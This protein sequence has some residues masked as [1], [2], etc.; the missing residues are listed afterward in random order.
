MANSVKVSIIIPAYNAAETFAETLETVL[1]QTYPDW[2]AIIVNDG[3]SDDTAAIAAS[4]A[5]RDPRIRLISQSQGGEGAARNTGIRLARFDW[6]FF[7]DADDWI[8]PACLERITNALMNNPG[9]DAVHCGWARIAPDGTLVGEHR[10][11]QTG[12]LFLAFANLCAFPVHAC[13]IRRAFVEAVGYF[14][15]SLRTCA[16][17]DLWQRVARMGARFGSVSDV[18]VRYRMRPNSA[19]VDGF[20]FLADGLGRV[21]QGH[22]PDP[23]V[24][25]PN[26]SHANGLPAEQLPGAKLYF[27]CWPAGMV[28][29]RGGDARP[30]LNALSGDH[31][32]A[33][34]PERVAHNIF[35]ATLLPICQPPTIWEKLWPDLEQRVN[36]FLFAL[37]KQ[38][39]ATGLVRRVRI[40]LERLIL[41]HSTTPWP[42]TIGTTHAIKV[43]V[44]EPIRDVYPSVSME[45]LQCTVEIEGEHLGT[46]ELPVCDGLVS[47]YVLADAIASEFAWLIV[48]R[49]F[50]HTVYQELSLK[51]GSNGL[52]LQRGNLCLADGLTGMEYP[53]QAERPPPGKHEVWQEIHKQVGWTVFLQ[54]IWG[55]P[56]WPSSYF[57]DPGI[58]EQVATQCCA[59]NGWFI[60]EV[61]KD[62]PDVEVS[63]QEL[64][65]VLMVGGVALGVV[66]IPAKQGFVRAHELR[67]ALT[68][69]G[70]YELCRVAVR[71]GLLGKPLTESTP[72]RGRLAAAAQRFRGDPVPEAS[73]NFI[74]APGSAQ[75]LSRA[76]LPD[77][78][79]MVIGQRAH[80]VIGTSISRRAGF[81]AAATPE[82]VEAALVSGE[83]VIQMPSTCEYP[84]R[85]VYAP[86]LVWRP[87]L[88]P[89]A[90]ATYE[91]ILSLLPFTRSLFRRIFNNKAVTRVLGYERSSTVMTDRLPILMY[92][93][94]APTGTPV[95]ARYRVT[96]EAFEEQLRYLRDHGFYSVRLEDWRK[97][98]I[99]QKPLPGRAILLTFDDGYL[100]FLTYAWSLLS[101]YGFSAI[102]FLVAEEIGGSNRWDRV[103]GEEVP[104]LGWKEIRRLCDEGIEFGSHSTSHLRLTALPSHEIVREGARSRA[105][106]ERGLGLP[107]MSFAYPHGAEDRVVQHLIGAC[108]YVFGLSCRSGL[109][110]LHDPL[111]ALPRIEVTGSDSLQ[112]FIT[113]LGIHPIESKR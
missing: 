27:V 6:L 61:S 100:D 17:W 24:P 90:L 91:R 83:P 102:V 51:R 84:K 94:I 77:E 40:V 67:I 69:V 53:L 38:S 108:G 88:H 36:E 92:H 111:L 46:L 18:L 107:V 65:V 101:R 93:R 81:P 64:N 9:L 48:G 78:R 7:L 79:G 30:L 1:A 45:R 62:L 71:E 75:A 10:C 11:P 13:M 42:R 22:S 80:G 37:E 104:L 98:M 113:K 110:N 26:P 41:E 16:D 28:L 52:S 19:W 2:E 99:A 50:A 44:T 49:F 21:I 43:E 63:G 74:P 32:P 54:E 68:N 3:S 86:D 105:I 33:L 96:P 15:T 56:D 97:A 89:R 106:L 109:S 59:D 34:N 8:L 55:H 35:Y 70:G 57:Y 23:R 72:L 25:N 87:V 82:L 73:G 31:E 14:D 5:K 76:L 12:D 85:V 95:L 60:V 103:Y 58:R 47:G 112:E 66:N 20:Q 29:G 4:F 39:M